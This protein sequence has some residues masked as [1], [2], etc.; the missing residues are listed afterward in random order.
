LP[1][2][3][4]SPTSAPVN[5]ASLIPAAPAGSAARDASANAAR[6]ASAAEDERAAKPSA[7]DIA[8]VR[9]LPPDETELV[10]EF[11]NKHKVPTEMWFALL[12]ATRLARAFIGGRTARI[13]HVR[14]RLLA[15]SNIAHLPGGQSLFGMVFTID[16]ELIADIVAIAKADCTHGLD[17]IPVSLRILAIRCL[18]SLCLD[19]NRVAQLLTSAGVSSHHGALP[20]MLRAQVS[21]LLSS[22]NVPSL[23]PP[24]QSIA[25]GA[26]NKFPSR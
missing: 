6:T 11:A 5:V 3:S 15:T 18:T 14:L 19:R 2:R 1:L 21:S 7:F 25:L 22:Q 12:A 24:S 9:M 26:S 4:S 20:S 23:Q 8:D 17:D 16:P 13:E 10:G